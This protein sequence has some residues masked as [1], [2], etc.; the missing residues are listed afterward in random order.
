MEKQLAKLIAANGYEA[1]MEALRS[2]KPQAAFGYDEFDS[3]FRKC[4]NA[5]G[6]HNFVSLV[7][8]RK[9]ANCNRE[10]FDEVLEVLRREYKY[11]L[12][13]AEGRFGVSQEER[14]ASIRED[15]MLML[16]VSRRPCK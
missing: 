10:T 1:V 13:S 4:D 16:Y 15:G 8:L 3:A 9:E 11:T 6:N 7:N 12:S 14:E 2:M 5:K